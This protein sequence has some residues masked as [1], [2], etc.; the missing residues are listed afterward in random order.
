M[1]SLNFL[2]ECYSSKETI[3]KMAGISECEIDAF[4]NNSVDGVNDELKCRIA[5]IAMALRFF[6]KDI[7]S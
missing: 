2:V 3:S 6:L 1:V 5:S 7:E 4:L